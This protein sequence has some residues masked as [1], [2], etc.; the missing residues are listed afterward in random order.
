MQEI[1]LWLPELHHPSLRLQRRPALCPR[2]RQ[3]LRTSCTRK[4]FGSLRD[5]QSAQGA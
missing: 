4:K 1:R 5:G 2:R 3:C